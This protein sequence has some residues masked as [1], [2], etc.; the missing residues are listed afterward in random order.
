MAEAYLNIYDVPNYNLVGS[1][2]STTR[3]GTNIEGI[4]YGNGEEAR[5]SGGHFNYFEHIVMDYAASFHLG[6]WNTGGG[7]SSPCDLD[8]N[9][10]TNVIDVQGGVNQALGLAACTADINLDQLC[11]VVDVQRV[12]TAALGGQCVAP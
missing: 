6:P 8:K 10:V 4:R 11:N 9:G 1:V 3:R 12:V 7:G 5:A 2:N